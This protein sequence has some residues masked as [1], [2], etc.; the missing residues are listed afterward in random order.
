MRP[1]SRGFVNKRK[2]SRRFRGAVKQTKYANVSR[3]SMR[4]GWRL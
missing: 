4:G 2:S 1:V 3:G